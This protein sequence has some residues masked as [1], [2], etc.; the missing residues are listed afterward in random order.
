[1]RREHSDARGQALT[2]YI[3]LIGLLLLVCVLGL[4]SLGVSVRDMYCAVAV[5]LGMDASCTNY[6]YD[7]FSDLDGWDIDRGDWRI[8]DGQLCA[9][10]GEGR[11]FRDVSA[12]DYVINIDSATL[13]Q[14]NGYA[15]F[16]RVTNPPRFNG[17][18]FQYDPG[19]GGAFVFR[20]WVNGRELWPPF[21]KARV[22]GYD[23]WNTPRQIKL[24]IKGDTFAAYVDGEPVLTATD[25]TYSEGGIGLRTW[26]NTIVCLDDLSVTRIP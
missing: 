19:L 10:P 11:I 23:W 6:L 21:A 16:F 7:D 3:L 26:N 25:A 14:G 20:K 15:V 4:A 13:F 5:A 9:G 12:D 8:D 18:S 2:E 17:Y 22:K 1:M 24:V